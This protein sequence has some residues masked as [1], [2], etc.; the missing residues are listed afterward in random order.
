MIHSLAGG[1]MR[2]LIIHDYAKVEILEGEFIGKFA[3]YIFNIIDL[4]VNDLVLVPFGHNP[5]A[6]RAKV[7]K[8]ERNFS[9]QVAPVTARHIKEIIKKIEC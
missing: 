7:L 2:D 6:T 4:K 9:S 5:K 3:W 8:I 1:K